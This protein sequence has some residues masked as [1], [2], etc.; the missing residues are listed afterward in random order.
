[1]VSCMYYFTLNRIYSQL[2]KLAANSGKAEIEQNMLNNKV[3]TIT[4]YY[5]ELILDP[6]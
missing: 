2:I 3:K 1:M 4:A 5:G 6:E